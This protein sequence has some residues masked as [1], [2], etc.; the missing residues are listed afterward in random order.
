MKVLTSEQEVGEESGLSPVDP[1][2]H[3]NLQ[4]GE[5][6]EVP[7]YLREEPPQDADKDHPRPE[8]GVMWRV[9]GGLFS[10]TRNVV[11][12]TLGG[13]A[14]VG[15]KSFE[16]TKTAVTSVPSA[17]VGL[18]KGS[19]SVVTGGVGAVGSA[20]ASKVTPKKKDKAD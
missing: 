13:V 4:E 15:S 3:H 20:V 11:G 14:W 18:V 7:P 9:G 5:Q 2:N 10:M 1:H 8:G 19:V 16:L 17:G 12:A 6:E